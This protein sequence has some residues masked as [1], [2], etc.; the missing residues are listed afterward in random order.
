MSSWPAPRLAKDPNKT[1]G[2]RAH[3]ALLKRTK[4]NGGR[5]MKGSS[6]L[7][8]GVDRSFWEIVFTQIE[9]EVT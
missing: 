3:A 5:L 4:R 2:F 9:R 8:I 7:L 6:A 1:D